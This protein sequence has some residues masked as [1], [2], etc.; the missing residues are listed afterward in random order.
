MSRNCKA[1]RRQLKK[2]VLPAALL[3]LLAV[4][5]WRACLAPTRILVVN[6]TLAQQ[7]DMALNNDNRHIRL[8][9]LDA[10]QLDK[11]PSTDALMLFSRGLYLDEAQTAAVSAS[12]MNSNPAKSSTSRSKIRLLCIR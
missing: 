8:R 9:F 2:I 4:V 7:A 3:V 5:F 11:V 1:N 12:P 6:A 10:D